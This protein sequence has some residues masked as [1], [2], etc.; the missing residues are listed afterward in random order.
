MTVIDKIRTYFLS[1]NINQYTSAIDGDEI[2]K[3]KPEYKVACRDPLPGY[4]WP[5]VRE[6]SFSLLAHRRRK[7]PLANRIFR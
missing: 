5:V 7:R 1:R 3:R 2:D 4:P 6:W